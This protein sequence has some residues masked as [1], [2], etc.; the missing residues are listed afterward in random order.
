MPAISYFIFA[1]FGFSFWFLMAVPFASHR[2]SYWWLA[3][4]QSHP[5]SQAF[6][7]I[8][9]TYR[10]LSQP[11][12]WLAFLILDPRIF[13]TSVCHWLDAFSVRLAKT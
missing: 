6:G 13:P 2:E 7:V 8:S 4:V 9:S 5:F 12:T 10:P 1:V 3:M 11:A